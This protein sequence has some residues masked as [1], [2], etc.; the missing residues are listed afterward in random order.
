M[1]LDVARMQNNTKQ[2]KNAPSFCGQDWELNA[3]D[4][5]TNNELVKPEVTGSA[6]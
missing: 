1:A 2:N 4:M 5:G 3:C 6:A